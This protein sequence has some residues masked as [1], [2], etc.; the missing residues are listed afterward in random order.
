MP[1]KRLNYSGRKTITSKHFKVVIEE[2]DG[3]PEFRVQHFNLDEFNF[4]NEA[5]IYWEFSNPPQMKRYSWGTIDDPS[6]DKSTSLSEIPTLAAKYTVKL[7]I[8]NAPDTGPSTI[9]AVSKKTPVYRTI[10]IDQSINPNGEK[11]ILKV[12]ARNIQSVWELEFDDTVG[13][14]LNLNENINKI[15]QQLSRFSAFQALVVPEICKQVYEEINKKDTENEEGGW[16]ENWLE[17]GRQLAGEE[18]YDEDNKLSKDWI[19]RVSS[20]LSDSKKLIQQYG[21]L[22]KDG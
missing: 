19:R 8:I 1:I 6:T 18:E 5:H 16:I 10:E 12:Q 4:P 21:N 22:I 17:F 14:I 15:D 7:K 13:P 9:L 3:G 2:T 11:S 20:G